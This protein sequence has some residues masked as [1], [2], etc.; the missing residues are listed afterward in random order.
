MSVTCHLRDHHILIENDVDQPNTSAFGDF[1]KHAL[2][3]HEGAAVRKATADI[4]NRDKANRGGATRVFILHLLAD[5]FSAWSTAFNAELHGHAVVASTVRVSAVPADWPED[6]THPCEWTPSEFANPPA[7]LAQWFQQLQTLSIDQID[8]KL[9]RRDNAEQLFAFRLL[10]DAKRL[11]GEAPFLT[12]H[13]ITIHAP[14][15]ISDWLN[16][17]GVS[18]PDKMPEVASRIGS[19]EDQRKAQTVL[20]AVIGNDSSALQKAINDFLGDSAK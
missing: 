13:G 9:L 17:F 16:P 15:S 2:L 14:V 1:T 7:R 11:C 3:R 10:C 5:D 18:D 12:L 19:G 8:W 4:L 6:R 20:R